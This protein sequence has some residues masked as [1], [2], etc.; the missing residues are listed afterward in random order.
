MIDLLIRDNFDL[1][2]AKKPVQNRKNLAPQQPV[3]VPAR[4]RFETSVEGIFE[5][6]NRLYIYLDAIRLYLLRQSPVQLSADEEI[7][8][9]LYRLHQFGLKTESKIRQQCNSARFHQN[10]KR[11]IKKPREY[12]P[13]RKI[14]NISRKITG[15][16][17]L[18]FRIPGLQP[19]YQFREFSDLISGKRERTMS[20]RCHTEAL[21]FLFS[22]RRNRLN[23]K[24]RQEIRQIDRL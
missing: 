15:D 17:K 9:A 7:T 18:P 22:F 19:F 2:P 1:L 5:G 8:P 10:F 3:Q 16:I 24:V 14:E 6:F 12:H 11:R 21:K 20:R 23:V 4:K 13:L